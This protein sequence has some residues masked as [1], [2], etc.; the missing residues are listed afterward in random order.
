MDDSSSQDNGHQRGGSVEGDHAEPRA[1]KGKYHNWT[2]QQ[3]QSLLSMIMKRDIHVMT[4]ARGVAALWQEV[5]DEFNDTFKCHL[6]K[7]SIQSHYRSTI[8][9]VVEEDKQQPQTGKASASSLAVSEEGRAKQRA[10]DQVLGQ[11]FRDG[12][13]WAEM[14]KRNSSFEDAEANRMNQPIPSEPDHSQTLAR[15]AA[16]REGEMKAEVAR[17]KHEEEY[18]TRRLAIEE[19]TLSIKREKV[20]LERERVEIERARLG[21]M[22]EELALRRDELQERKKMRESNDTV[23]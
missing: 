15:M 21:M 20:R 11:D 4:R 7:P 2:M 6:T 16:A 8:K 18:H 13:L 23:L 17:V 10:R 9:S 5:V 22:A 19:E 14:E 12:D 3:T 1:K